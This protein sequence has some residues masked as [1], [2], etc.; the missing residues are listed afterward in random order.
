MSKRESN[1]TANVRRT[2]TWKQ[3]KKKLIINKDFNTFK[4]MQSEV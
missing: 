3:F 1:Y 4:E 2:Y